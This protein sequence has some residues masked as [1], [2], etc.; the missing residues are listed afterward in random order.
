MIEF[1]HFEAGRCRAMVDERFADS[2][3]A[4]METRA[5]ALSALLEAAE[6]AR[7]G[8]GRAPT[9][10]LELPGRSERIHLRSSRRGGLLGRAFTRRLRGEARAQR[11]LDV[12]AKLVGLGI[13][14]AQPVL[15]RIVTFCPV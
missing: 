12:S 15:A 5:D 6:P 1:R 2:V 3:A 8:H 14:V 9:R 10:I 7:H 11:E 13:P 4:V